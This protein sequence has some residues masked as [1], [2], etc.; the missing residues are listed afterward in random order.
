[1]AP[2]LQ[3][4]KTTAKKHVLLQLWCV[5]TEHELHN[6]PA[7]PYLA[8]ISSLQPFSLL[9]SCMLDTKEKRGT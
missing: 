7:D 4:L 2:S 9:P 3:Q 6:G 1:M 5:L 8:R